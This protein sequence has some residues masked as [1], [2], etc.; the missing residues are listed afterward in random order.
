MLALVVAAT[1]EELTAM[2]NAICGA[3][4]DCKVCPFSD[5][6]LAL[7]SIQNELVDDVFVSSK[8]KRITFIEFIRVA[9]S[10]RPGL[11]V[12]VFSE[13]EEYET[14]ARA[15]GADAFLLYPPS[16]VAVRKALSSADFGWYS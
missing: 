15:S 10:I 9:R 12:T 8:I 6:L 13:K 7:R 11:S 16:Q 14:L 5:P 2:S 4:Q 1:A 3:V